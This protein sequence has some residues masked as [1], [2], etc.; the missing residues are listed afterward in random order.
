VAHVIWTPHEKQKLADEYKRLRANTEGTQESCLATAMVI[1]PAHRRKNVKDCSSKLLRNIGIAAE[2]PRAGERV[3]IAKTKAKATVTPITKAKRVRSV[4]PAPAPLALQGA[5][6]AATEN[7]LK[8]IT[9]EVASV[10]GL[11]VMASV[12]GHV[13]DALHGMFDRLV[14]RLS[15]TVLK[16]VRHAVHV[17]MPAPAAP[18]EPSVQNITLTTSAPLDPNTTSLSMAPRDRKPKVVVIGLMSQQQQEIRKEFDAVCDL[19]FVQSQTMTPGQLYGKDMAFVMVKF[20]RHS[21]E[22]ACRS[23]GVPYYRVTGA[24]SHLRGEMRKW[25]NGEIA[26]AEVSNV[27]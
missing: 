19:S 21:A 14:K 8:A 2:N 23:Y 6:G 9:E 7:F 22:E 10:I 13:D 20:S 26:I 17:S 11:Q 5:I 12:R 3:T 18:P 15:E 4:P 16:E 27:Q 24:V 1:L 25:I